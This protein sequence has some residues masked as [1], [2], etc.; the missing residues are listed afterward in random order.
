MRQLDVVTSLQLSV[1]RLR[2][3]S[4]FSSWQPSVML[5]LADHRSDATCLAS[6]QP[7]YATE[8][9]VNFPADGYGKKRS[10]EVLVF[11]QAKSRADADAALRHQTHT[12][13]FG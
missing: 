4:T 9:R 8:R 3:H 12:R 11:Q 2:F 5:H 6:S 13:R 7:F 10:V 1:Q